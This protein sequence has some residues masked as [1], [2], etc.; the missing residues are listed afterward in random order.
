MPETYSFHIVYIFKKFHYE[1]F[2]K[3]KF[4]IDF[5]IVRLFEFS[6]LNSVRAKESVKLV[7]Y[8]F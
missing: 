2:E 3:T 7:E 6:E 8:C 4:A 1:K 5:I